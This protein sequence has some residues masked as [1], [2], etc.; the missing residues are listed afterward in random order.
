MKWIDAHQNTWEQR[1]G[2][3]IRNDFDMFAFRAWLVAEMMVNNLE[4]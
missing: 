1:N 4:I 2:R 3:A